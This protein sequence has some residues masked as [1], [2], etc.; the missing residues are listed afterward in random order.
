MEIKDLE[1]R[2]HVSVMLEINGNFASRFEDA[3]KDPKYSH[4]DVHARKHFMTVDIAES[5]GHTYT[6]YD[7]LDVNF[8]KKLNAISE[9]Y[10]IKIGEVA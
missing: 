6:Q 10:K 8:Q 7:Y 1:T 5:T 3:S 2:S 4:I 9:A